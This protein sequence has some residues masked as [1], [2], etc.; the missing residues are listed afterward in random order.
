MARMRAFWGRRLSATTKPRS[1]SVVRGSTRPLPAR[2]DSTT[3]TPCL[4]AWTRASFSAAVVTP[5]AIDATTIA[6]APA[7][8][9]ASMAVPSAPA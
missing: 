8:T 2:L 1:R 7:A 4:R 9:K 5:G 6:R 3:S